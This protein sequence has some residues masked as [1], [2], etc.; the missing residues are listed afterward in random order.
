MELTGDADVVRVGVATMAGYVSPRGGSLHVAGYALPSDASKVRRTVSVWSRED[1][2]TLH[3]LRS[4]LHERVSSSPHRGRVSRGETQ[5]LVAARL[6]TLRQL[7]ATHQAVPGQLDSTLP[8]LLPRPQQILAY[9][10]LALAEEAPITFLHVAEWVSDATERELW[11]RAIDAFASPDQT[12]ILCTTNA[13][14]AL[15][16]TSESVIVLERNNLVGVR[17]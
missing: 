9:A 16:A 11:W 8:G 2:D 3:P 1:R 14:D 17:R 15:R 6:G 10:A 13:G 7:M 5:R 4:S 12:V